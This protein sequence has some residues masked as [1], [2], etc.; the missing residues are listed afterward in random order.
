[1]T[2]CRR[3]ISSIDVSKSIKCSFLR[4]YVLIVL[5][6]LLS[7]SY[8]TVIVYD[9]V[10]RYRHAARVMY[11]GSSFRGWQDQDDAKM[12]TVQGALSHCLS[13]RF[14]MQIRATGSSRTDLGV[15]S[16]GQAVHIDLPQI[17]DP[18]HFEYSMNR[19][20]PNDIK[21]YN[22]T[23]APPGNAEQALVNEP[24]H[25]TKSAIGKLY[26]Y[27]FCTNKFVD[28]MKRK[29]CAH[30]FYPVDLAFLEELLQCF[31]GSH[32]FKSYA[33]RIEQTSRDFEERS[34]EFS[35]MKTIHSI[36]LVDDGD[37]YYHVDFHIQS[38]LYKMIRNIM[39]T[40][41]DVANG[42][43]SKD[44]ILYLLEHAP[45]RNDNK[46]KSAPPEGLCLEHVF[47]DHY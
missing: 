1:M 7:I 8:A 38:A 16:H 11:D 23:L 27:R 26:S 13:K 5:L 21:L 10:T 47:Y 34:V 41:L 42:R 19:L 22:V 14:D 4:G 44:W 28:P 17:M 12:R 24:W 31:V 9:G 43:Y 32:N 46:S 45:S 3:P 18:G 40:A 39:G 25:A 36:R 29:Y 20:L 37:G 30:V 33:N 35:T 15:H 2:I 6:Q